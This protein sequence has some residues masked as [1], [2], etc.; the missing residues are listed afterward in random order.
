MFTIF[1]R[2]ELTQSVMIDQ[3]SFVQLEIKELTNRV[4]CLTNQEST[5]L[6][7]HSAALWVSNSQM[8]RVHQS[9]VPVS[10]ATACIRCYYRSNSW[11]G[12]DYYRVLSVFNGP[13]ETVWGKTEI[14]LSLFLTETLR[15]WKIRRNLRNSQTGLSVNLSCGQ[16]KS[17]RFSR[18]VI[19][20]L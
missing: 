3:I 1:F 14:L 13:S 5:P 18:K 2:L 19:T 16:Q 10:V 15:N 11:L 20:R 7:R 6:W 4:L 12:S 17:A 8:I 9:C